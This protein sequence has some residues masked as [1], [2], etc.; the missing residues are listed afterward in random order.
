MDRHDAACGGPGDAQDAAV[1]IG[2][3]AAQSGEALFCAQIAATL[4]RKASIRSR[5]SDR[6]L[7]NCSWCGESVWAPMVGSGADRWALRRRADM[8]PGAT[9]AAGSS[10]SSNTREQRRKGGAAGGGPD[11][12]AAVAPGRRK[13]REQGLPADAHLVMRRRDEKACPP[14][15]RTSRAAR[16]DVIA[17]QVRART[18][19]GGPLPVACAPRAGLRTLALITGR[20]AAAAR[21][22]HSVVASQ[23]PWDAAQD[24]DGAGGYVVAVARARG[25]GRRH[26]VQVQD[27]QPAPHPP[28]A[29]GGWSWPAGGDSPGQQTLLS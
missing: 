6:Q 22:A 14:A 29:A 18:A 7:R 11:T 21:L 2:P 9:G 25:R 20:T 26:R 3:V 13:L 16:A 19:A 12:A 5:E 4:G 1:R 15:Q 23:C 24:E 10:G 27:Q 8:A 28:A 17:Q